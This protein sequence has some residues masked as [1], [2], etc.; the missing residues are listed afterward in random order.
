V[1]DFMPLFPDRCSRFLRRAARRLGQEHGIS[2]LLALITLAVLSTVGG[3]VAVYTSSNLRHSY[4]DSSSANAYHLA[5][6]GLAEALAR[7]QGVDDPTV[8]TLLSTA[9]TRNDASLGGS[10]TYSGSAVGSPAPPAVQDR[11]TWTLT[12][13]GTAGNPAK[14]VTLSQTAVVRYLVQGGN[15]G[16]WSR[17]YQG[18]ATHCLTIDTVTMPAPL[19]TPGDLCLVNGGE[20]TG[21]STSVKVGGRVFIVGPSVTGTAHYPAAAAN[22]TNPTRVSANDASYAT[23]TVAGG[24][25]IGLNLDATNLSLG[26]PTGAKILGI[27]AQV[28]RLASVCCNVNEVQ[29][30]SE[31]GSPTAGTFTLTGTPP[32]GSSHTSVSIARNATAATVQS[33]LAVSTMYGTGNV[34]CTGGPLPTAVSCSFTGTYAS[35][36]VSTMT[37]TKTSFFPSTATVVIGN[38]TNGVNATM[39]DGTVQL[40]KAGTAVGNNKAGSSTWSNTTST[41]VTYGSSSDLWGTTWTA[42]DLNATNFGLRFA[43]KNTGAASAT[44]SVDWIALTVTYNDDT[45][46]IG[47]SVA[48]IHDV[49]VGT[50][51]QYN[52]QAAH[53]PCSATDHVNAATIESGPLDPSLAL[54]QLDLDYWF[55]HSMPG[56][57]HPCTNSG[58]NLAPLSFDN[59]NST[60][61]NNSL[62][63]DNSPSYDI[64]P[65]TRDYD[66]QVVAN[67][68][69]AGRLAWNHTTHVLTIGGQIF[70]DGD[71]RFDDDGQLVHYQGRA[72]IYAAGDIEFDELVCAGGHDTPTTGSPVGSSCATN[73]SSWDPNHNYLTLQAEG[74]AEYDQGGSSCSNLVAGQTCAG[75]HPQSGFQGLVSAQGTCTIHERFILS[76]PV[77]CKNIDLPYE[78][79]G[80][81][82]YYPFP[83]LGSLIDGQKYGDENSASAYELQPGPQSGG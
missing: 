69:V 1:K 42:A 37:F 74:N 57:K 73:M 65:L 15:I 75:S 44:P 3:G 67:G 27:K 59:D 26:I 60:T 36:P 52:A 51:C 19:A 68:A 55:S 20:I 49:T 34:T 46:G 16:A 31:T 11:V 63:F 12:S 30:I 33:A 5:Q 25:V 38:P 45:T 6:A 23:N 56:P 43:V 10:Y 78:S 50:T 82:T 81:P 8:L 72:M 29:T 83:A 35:M 14:S 32:G 76:G 39:Q 77:L 70:F 2:L 40:L 47:T 54:P 13:K 7:L 48:P 24:G 71:V 58:N 28:E 64:T 9:T 41:T 53:N 79:D 18:D 66:C 22:W 17:F 62:I 80:W 61:S 21:A 4:T